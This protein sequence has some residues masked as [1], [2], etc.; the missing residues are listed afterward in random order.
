MLEQTLTYFSNTDFS[1]AVAWL[2]DTM[3]QADDVFQIELTGPLRT[4]TQ[5]LRLSLF[6]LSVQTIGDLIRARRWLSALSLFAFAVLWFDVAIVRWAHPALDA[7]ATVASLVQN[8][9]LLAYLW[10]SNLHY[11]RA[12]REALERRVRETFF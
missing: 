4:V 1:A 12:R 7:R 9:S 2:L 3:R 11:M 5:L 10:F 8:A 6:V